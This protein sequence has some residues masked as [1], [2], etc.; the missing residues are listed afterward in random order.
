[1][2]KLNRPHGEERAA[3]REGERFLRT[4]C[5]GAASF[6]TPPLLRPLLRMR[7][8]RV[9]LADDRNPADRARARRRLSGA[10]AVGRGAAALRGRHGDRAARAAHVPR[11]LQG[12]RRSPSAACAASPQMF[13]RKGYQ[14]GWLWAYGTVL[15]QF[16]AGALRRARPVHAADGAAAIRP[17]GAL[18]LRPRQI[19]RLFLEQVGHR[20][21]RHVG[22]RRA[23]F[24]DQRRRHDLARP[25]ADRLEF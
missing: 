6:E 7:A 10:G 3:A 9:T 5:A 17:D 12:H 19:R 14:P 15:T 21:S 13:D 1:M 25:S 22:G 24:P 20:I 2:S 18:R 4:M 8:D 16:V 23:L 11:L